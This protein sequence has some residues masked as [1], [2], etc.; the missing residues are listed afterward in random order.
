MQAT[1]KTEILID[2]YLAINKNSKNAFPNNF[3]HAKYYKE[4]KESFVYFHPA[5]PIVNLLH[6]HNKASLNAK[7]LTVVKQN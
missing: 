6:N 3:G 2:I 7:T 5:F 1:A 4:T